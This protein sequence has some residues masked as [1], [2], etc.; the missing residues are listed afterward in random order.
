MRQW[1]VSLLLLT[2]CSSTPQ[3]DIPRRLDTFFTDLHTKGMFDG[4]V[5]VA[6]GDHIVWE[7]GFGYADADRQIPFTPDTPTDGASLAK[8]FTAALL[9]EL[10]GER[11]LDLD[12]PARNLLPELPYP[13]ITLRQL[14]SHSSG[15]PV[16][17]YDWFDAFLP[18]DE[19]RTTEGLLTVLAAQKP[20]LAFVPGTAFEYSSFGFDL[21]A[22]AAARASRNPYGQILA[23]RFFRPLGITSAFLRPGRFSEFPHDRTRGYRRGVNG[24]LVPHEVFDREGFHGGSNIYISARDLHRWN[25]SFLTRPLLGSTALAQSLKPAR[26]DDA[27]SGLTLGS[28]YRSADNG[29]FWYSGHLQG[30]HS[31]V[32]RNMRTRSSIVYVSNNT[33][34][35]WLQKGLIRG[36]TAILSGETPP[37]LERPAWE[38]IRKED[39]VRLQGRWVLTG[40]EAITV[41]S[42]GHLE[43]QRNGVG[44]RMIQIHP[45]AFYVPGLDLIIGFPAESPGSFSKIC[46]SSNMAE[47]CGIR[48]GAAE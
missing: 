18:P 31:E 32:F 26:I 7:R 10:D 44:Y 34:D 13:E 2:A 39:Y 29:A 6:D 4:A 17:D 20:Q 30:F 14:L 16:A 43:I 36:V 11:L 1:I 37:N 33:I 15:I 25:A 47:Q 8:T 41:G 9:I 5:V 45:L 27:P 46:L 24:K 3:P 23:E 38:E 35:P 28:W 40:G 48:A 22:L 12:A 19:V 42:A 21:A